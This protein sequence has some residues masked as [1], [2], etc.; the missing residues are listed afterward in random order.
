MSRRKGL[1]VATAIVLPFSALCGSVLAANL[2]TPNYVAAAVSDAGRTQWDVARDPDR[3]PDQVL[4]FSG[5][6][7]GMIVVDLIP[8]DAYY[9]RMLSA[10]VGPKGKVY[11][12]LPDTGASGRGG[13]MAQRARELP[14]SI[15]KEPMQAC[16]L[17][18]Y[19]TGPGAYM[20]AEDS[21]LA[22]ENIHEYANVTVMVESL[23]RGEFGIPE[24]ADAVF[25]VDGYHEL[26]YQNLVAPPVS[27]AGRNAKPKPLNVEA[28]DKGIFRA[29]KPGGLFIIADYA[30]AKGTG[31]GAA[32]SLHRSE[33][34]AV[35]AEL[36]AAGFNFDGESRA[37]AL[38]ADD[39]SKL[40]DG[41]NAQRDK[42]DQFLLRF[43][44]P[45]NAPNTDHRPKGEDPLKNYYGNTIIH[46]VAAKEGVT[47]KD[48][49]IIAGAMKGVTP[50]G[51]RVRY[52]YFN[53]DG[54]YE[55]FG[56]IDE[57]PGP[58]QSGVWFWDAEIGR[59]HV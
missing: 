57:G 31:F 24:Q 52:S 27:L 15:P 19:E 13:R 58:M 7:P 8:G 32:D 38:S 56:R 23:G 18:C 5:I 30:A 35:K 42:N 1:T 36:A 2:T 40:A 3:K 9:T 53:A 39:H 14:A 16:V 45:A 46:G 10:L 25:S 11:A 34:D 41:T 48:G 12:F 4:A 22:I 49:R 50:E 20:L 59:A 33:A 17:G 37:L 26:H 6:K 47:V 29:L 28:A 21:L 54:T 44:K 51:A 55:E 43:R